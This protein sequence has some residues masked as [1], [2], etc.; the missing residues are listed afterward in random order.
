MKSILRL[1]LTF[2]IVLTLVGITSLYLIFDYRPLTA[3]QGTVDLVIQDGATLTAI[4]EQLFDAGIIGSPTT[5]KIAAQ[6]LRK[7]RA[8][9]PGAYSLDQ[10]STNTE[11][12]EALAHAKAIEIKITIERRF[13][14]SAVSY[15][16]FAMLVFDV[17]SVCRNSRSISRMMLMLERGGK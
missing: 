8:I 13:I 10:R 6:L 3:E 15:N 16:C 4:S 7:N 1:T 17:G 11:A 2:F 5:F 14:S 9:Y 12:I